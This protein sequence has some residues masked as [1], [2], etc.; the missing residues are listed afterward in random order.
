[1][2]S[3]LASLIFF[4]SF[5]SDEKKTENVKICCHLNIFLF[6]FFL[7][8]FVRKLLTVLK[9]KFKLFSLSLSLSI[10]LSVSISFSLYSY[11]SLSLSRFPKILYL[12]THLINNLLFENQSRYSFLSL[13][14]F[15]K[16]FEF[17]SVAKVWLERSWKVLCT[18]LN[19]FSSLQHSGFVS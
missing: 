2:K 5:N 3:L 8:C 14:F 17:N 15:T 1:M 11:F 13:S 18:L 12:K 4:I 7:F 10:S 19:E 16:W 6:P 9:I